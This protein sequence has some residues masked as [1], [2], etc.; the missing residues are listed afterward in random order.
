MPILATERLTLRP[1]VREDA[2]AL[3]VWLSDPRVMRYWSTLPH[4][5]F[6]ET[7]RWVDLSLAETAA[8]RAHDHAVL[9]D[10]RLIGRVTFWQG[11]EIGFFFDP[12]VWGRGYAREALST[13]CAH[14]LADLGFNE[15]VA[16]VDP[17]NAASLA[18]LERI[19]FQRTGFAEKTLEI[20]GK[21][22]DSVYLALRR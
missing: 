16:D 13:F 11:N 1:L 18:V 5:N 20:D 8:G 15:I 19:G 4:R 21:W 9:L 22:F 7:L 17:D 6:D 10:G 3:H 14:G 12:A 2:T